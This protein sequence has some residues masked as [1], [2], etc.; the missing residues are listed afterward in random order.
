[1][2]INI[3]KLTPEL[4]EDYVHFFETTPHYYHDDGECNCYCTPYCND[5]FEE[6]KSL[7]TSPEAIRAYTFQCIR[8]S[9]LQGYLAYDGDKIVGWCNANTKSDCLKCNGWRYYLNFVPIEDVASGIKVK[10]VFC[11]VIAPEV[12]RKGIATLLLQRICQDAAQDGFDY[13]EA[14]CEKEFVNENEDYQGPAELYKKSGFVVS[15]ETEKKYV[16]RRLLK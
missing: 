11:F 4:A 14:Y 12:R 5:D 8:E 9:R 1:M 16:M 6:I 13:V 10:S 2:N 3:R 7:V 15:A